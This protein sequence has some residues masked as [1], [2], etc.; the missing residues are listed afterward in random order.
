M[1]FLFRG[2]GTTTTTTRFETL[3]DFA[4]T[5]SVPESC[6]SK[7]A[8]FLLLQKQFWFYCW[9]FCSVNLFLLLLLL[10]SSSL[11]FLLSEKKGASF[12]ECSLL[13]CIISAAF[14]QATEFLGIKRY[15]TT[16]RAVILSEFGGPD[17][18]RV[19]EDV[20]LPEL[21]ASEVLV[22]THAVGVNPLDLR[23]RGGY[24]CSLFK[25]LLPLVIGRDV[26]GEVTRVG[27]SVQHLHIGEQVFG[28]LHPTATR[29]TYSDYAILHEEQLTHKPDNISHTEAAAIPFAA[30]TAWRALRGTAQIK[31]GQ[32]ILVM[33][34]G[35]AVGLTAIQ[36][37]KST[38]CY[39]ACTCGKRSMELVKEAGAM[40]VIDYTTPNIDLQFTDRFDVV[41]DTIGLP[42]TEAAGIR[43][44]QP[45]GHYLTLQG[46][47][48]TL[49]DRYGLVAGGAAAAAVLLKKKIRYKQQYGIDYWWTIMRTDAEALEEIAGLIKD[50][51]LKVPVGHT[52]P[53]E[54]A[55]EAHRVREG[56]KAHGKVVLEVKAES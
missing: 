25:P 41:L 18:L 31:K 17:V 8:E 24:G 29:G 14:S 45:G 42:E 47:T 32:R 9:L 35:G 50:G 54:E 3:N 26:S 11:S 15:L 4:T 6:N 46:E 39:V 36:L 38:E 5:L 53:L 37:A 12:E 44:L 10:L 56:K 40:E 55:A 1:V 49:A 51:R 19:R 20:A 33:G 43:L 21:G 34:G 16:C 28:A 23:M 48:V 30:L 22:R 52:L 13:A 7:V 2:R 27:N